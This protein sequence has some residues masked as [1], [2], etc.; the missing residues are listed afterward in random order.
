[1]ANFDVLAQQGAKRFLTFDQ[2]EM[3]RRY[4]LC[5][6][7]E[8]ISLSFCGEACRVNRHSGAVA[9]AVGQPLGPGAM[10]TIYDMLC[11][12]TAPDALSG[13]WRTTNMLPGVGQSSPDDTRLNADWA[14]RLDVPSLAQACEAMGGTPFPVGEV[15]Y[16]LPVFDWFPVVFQL[17][18]G[19]EEFPPSMRFLWDAH[20]L[21][22]LRYETLYYVMDEVLTRLEAHL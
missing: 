19:D 3:C 17:W 10:L 21:Q 11:S 16:R 20:A 14:P 4:G 13:T 1:M 2:E 5:A 15:A 9:G 22:F 18:H 12:G 8:T 6:D 7:A